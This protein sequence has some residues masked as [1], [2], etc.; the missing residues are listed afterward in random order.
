M[1]LVNGGKSLIGRNLK[2]SAHQKLFKH[3]NVRIPA[4]KAVGKGET[5]K[6]R[7]KTA[8]KKYGN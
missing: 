2:S 5:D 7:W 8:P 6:G 1:L 4:W 3:K